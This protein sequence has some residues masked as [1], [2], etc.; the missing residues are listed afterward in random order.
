MNKFYLIL[1]VTM[2]SALSY[3][4]SFF[5][6]SGKNSS[7]FKFTTPYSAKALNSDIGDSYA[8]GR[9]ININDTNTNYE[10]A[11]TLNNFNPYVGSPESEVWYSLNYLGIDNAILYPIIG[12]SLGSS[13]VL[14]LRA[15]LSFNK[16]ISGIESIEGEIHNVKNFPEFNGL[17]IMGALGLQ[18]KI[19]VSDDINL[20]LGYNYG[21]S[22]LNTGQIKNESLS[23][24]S[25][26]IVVGV[27]F[28][29]H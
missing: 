15:G 29:L 5:I 16:L 1:I 11:L 25:H 13:F 3:S 10:I 18:T 4:Q 9:S 2:V 8:I 7:K 14:Q 20:S 12:S 19:D 23:V 22:L 27:H 26:Q 24:S 21:G 17:L 6:H 28:L